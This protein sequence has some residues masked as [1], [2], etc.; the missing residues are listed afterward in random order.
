MMF[1][2]VSYFMTPVHPP[3]KD[4][5]KIHSQKS[6]PI[7]LLSKMTFGAEISLKY[8]SFSSLKKDD[9]HT[10]GRT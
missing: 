6:L 4:S 5:L 2:L 1:G 3:N 10:F 8:F 9:S 7:D